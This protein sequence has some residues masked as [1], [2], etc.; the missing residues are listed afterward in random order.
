ML[1][2]APTYTSNNTHDSAP[3][4]IA[5]MESDEWGNPGG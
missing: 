1:I 5:A 2:G 3:P 4:S